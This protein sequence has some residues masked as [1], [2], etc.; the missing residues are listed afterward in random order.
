MCNLLNGVLTNFAMRIFL[1]NVELYSDY[2]LI[3]PFRSGTFEVRNFPG[4]DA[5]IPKLLEPFLIP[6]YFQMI[7]KVDADLYG[8]NDL[9]PVA[10][11]KALGVNS[12]FAGLFG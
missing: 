5:I 9:V 3:C 1:A 6:S 7:I 8:N 10:F 2:K 12:G 11:M 4:V